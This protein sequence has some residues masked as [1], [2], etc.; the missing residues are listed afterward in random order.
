MNDNVTS[1]DRGAKSLDQE[2]E[3]TQKESD[4][5]QIRELALLTPFEYDRVRI[6]KAEELKV[7]ISTMDKE[8]KQARKDVRADEFKI[9][10]PDP[11]PDEVNGAEVLNQVVDLFNSYL[12]LPDGA[13]EILALWAA[14][15]H[16]FRAFVH[17]PRL[18]ITSPEKEC[19]KTLLLDVLETVTPKA[20]RT[21][22]VTTAVLIRLADKKA[23]TLLVDEC[24]SFLKQH[25]EL[26]SAFNAGHKRGGQHLRCEGDN[27]EVK[28]F[29]TFAPVVLAGIRGLPPTLASRSIIIKLKRALKGE[30]RKRFDSRFTEQG[31]ELN[32]KLFRWAEDN[33][34]LLEKI[35]PELPQSLFNRQADNWRP[36][37]SIAEIAGGDWVS[38]AR[39]SLMAL[40]SNEDAEETYSVMLLEDIRGIFFPKNENG[41]AVLDA[42]MNSI[43]SSEL[44]ETLGKMEERPWPEY[45]KL[46]KQITTRQVAR[47]LKPFEINPTTHRFG[48][49]TFKGYLL[50]DFNDA[51]P[52]YLDDLS[53]TPS[54][55]SNGKDYSG[56]QSVTPVTDRSVT[57]VTNIDSSEPALNKDCYDVTDQTGISGHTVEQ[58]IRVLLH[59]IIDELG[60]PITVDKVLSELVPDDYQYLIN[61]PN[62]ARGFVKSL[63][64]RLGI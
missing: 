36:L 18:N 21:E 41:E 64:E 28:Y 58:E 47:L 32:Q 22:G 7:Q 15:T 45:G 29:K 38:K 54:Q 34:L 62:Y 39:N 50:G 11:W 1:I 30:R 6:E 16:A 35:D 10:P 53:V 63:L 20:L 57:S 56:D 33:F 2:T 12:V 48:D 23:P 14:H 44:A 8:V 60:R 49:N 59:T 42:I 46:A 37:F 31:K 27:N 25:N 13:A 52:R 5:D 26:V 4:E 61:D 51:F 40:S 24:D 9:D 43:T 17:T 55:P 3:R 19:G